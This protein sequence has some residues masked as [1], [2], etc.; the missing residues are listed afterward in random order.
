MLPKHILLHGFLFKQCAWISM[1]SLLAPT[2]G[3][4]APLVGLIFRATFYKSSH[5]YISV[6]SIP[7]LLKMVIFSSSFFLSNLP[8]KDL[9]FA[10]YSWIAELLCLFTWILYTLIHLVIPMG[11]KH[12]EDEPCDQAVLKANNL[13]KYDCSF[14]DWM[15]V[16][17]HKREVYFENNS[18]YC[19]SWAFCEG[20]LNFKLMDSG[21]VL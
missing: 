16:G 10:H 6:N 5:F 14:S 11:F 7:S 2:N 9:N 12:L 17:D 3:K 19:H 18:S 20:H 21:F 4:R 15:L 8:V 1:I 13:D